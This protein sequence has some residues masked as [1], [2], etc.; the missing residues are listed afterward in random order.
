MITLILP[1]NYTKKSYLSYDFSYSLY[2]YVGIPYKYYPWV[3]YENI[4]LNY[5]TKIR[6]LFTINCHQFRL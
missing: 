5:I 2:L 4:E 6:I 1:R 3:G